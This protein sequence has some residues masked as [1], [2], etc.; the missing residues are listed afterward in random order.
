MEKLKLIKHL[1][2]LSQIS[3]QLE[4]T[5]PEVS[6]LIDDSINSFI[7]EDHGQNFDRKEYPPISTP[8]IKTDNLPEKQHEAKLIVD[9]ILSSPQ[10][11][12]EL[13]KVKHSPN[14]SQVI[15]EF[16]NRH[17]ELFN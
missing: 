14:K 4:D 3:E 5:N 12:Q 16:L 9:E 13:Q 7:P 15:E 8:E 2:R 6:G 1:V 17:P 10:Y 11:S